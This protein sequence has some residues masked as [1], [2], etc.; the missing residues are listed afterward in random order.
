M[1]KL[2]ESADMEYMRLLNR[3]GTPEKSEVPAKNE[4]IRR[5]LVLNKDCVFLFVVFK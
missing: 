5:S 2:I 3:K 1:E 4:K